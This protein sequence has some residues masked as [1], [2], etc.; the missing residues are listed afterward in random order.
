[1]LPSGHLVFAHEGSLFAIPFDLKRLEASGRAVPVVEQVM[2]AP[3]IGGAQFS[4]S[5]NGSLVY[6]QGKPG[7]T[8][9]S[10]DWVGRDGK[11]QPLRQKTADIGDVEFSPDGKRMVFDAREGP[12]SDIWM[13]DWQRDTLTRLTFGGDSNYDPSWT[14]DGQRITYAMSEKGAVNLYWK[15]ADGSG[16]AQ[17]LTDFKGV[18]SYGSWSPDGKIM[19]F[20]ANVSGSRTGWDIYTLA[21]EGDEKKGW[22][23][24]EPRLFLGTPAGEVLPV[25]SPDGRWLAYA[26]N[27]SGAQEV[28]VRPFPGP[29]GKWQISSGGGW[30]PVWSHAN[31]ELLYVTPSQQIMYV[32]YSSTAD[33]FQAGQPKL[34]TEGRFT[35]FALHPDGKRL[36]VFKAPDGETQSQ[37]NKVVFVFN[38]FEELRHKLEAIR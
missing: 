24:G 34:W 30:K 5:D 36:A 32:T 15:R 14:P 7:G 21:M 9:V 13:Y 11:M 2:T 17:R 26:S 38:F 19:A 1:Y 28:Y 33:S 27:E 22:K 8:L 3:D 10:I 6:V 37:S 31:K 18:S 29:G 25:F 4:V 23:P 12:R 20:N 16:D 35:K